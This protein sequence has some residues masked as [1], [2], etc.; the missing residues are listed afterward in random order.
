[1]RLPNCWKALLVFLHDGKTL[2]V[3]ACRKYA[4]ARL[5]FELGCQ[6][7]IR[8]VN[9]DRSC[10]PQPV[11]GGMCDALL[12]WEVDPDEAR[13]SS[14]N[15]IGKPSVDA[16]HQPSLSLYGFHYFIENELIVSRDTVL[17]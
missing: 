16:F 5:T 10:P 15:G 14:Q 7:S 12:L 2:A 1:M 3:A 6:P 4:F 13:R 9:R 8:I 11:P 17:T